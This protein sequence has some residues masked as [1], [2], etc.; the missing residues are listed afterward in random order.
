MN[1]FMI[2]FFLALAQ[3]DIYFYK[4]ILI[5]MTAIIAY[6]YVQITNCNH[7]HPPLSSF[8]FPSTPSHPLQK[9]FL[10]VLLHL[11]MIL[12]YTQNM[13]SI[14]FH[15]IHHIKKISSDCKTS[16]SWCLGLL[17]LKESWYLIFNFKINIV[18]LNIN[19]K[20]FAC[21]ISFLK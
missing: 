7:I 15:N 6:S 19:H 21:F 20:F 12:K 11:D 1:G 10:N 2:P 14:S 16:N 9:I 3:E 13:L 4:C 5:I 8:T 18:I 17:S